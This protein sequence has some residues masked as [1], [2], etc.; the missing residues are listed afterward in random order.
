MKLKALL[1]LM[2]LFVPFTIAGC[3]NINQQTLST[4]KNVKIEQGVLQFNMVE[5]A[6]YYVIYFNNYEITLNPKYSQ[7]SS[8]VDGVVNYDATSIL[9][10][11]K[12]YRIKI[13]AIAEEMKDSAFTN[14]V[15]Y[16]Y[17]K[18]LRKPDNV[19]IV[20]NN[21][22]WDAVET[23]DEYVIKAQNLTKTETKEYK[24]NI[25][26]FDL[27]LALNELGAG[28]Y[29]LFVK[30]VRKGSVAC[31]G[32]YS[33]AVN[34]SNIVKLNTPNIKDIYELNNKIYMQ[35]ELDS[36]CNKLVIDCN[37][38]S[39]DIILTNNNFVTIS[40]KIYTINLT[41]ALSINL[42]DLGQYNFKAKSIYA[43]NSNCYYLDSDFSNNFIHNKTSK[44]AAPTLSLYYSAD[45]G[46]YIASWNSVNNATKYLIVII[47]NATETEKE[48]LGN[49]ILI[50]QPF[51]SIKVKA[52]GVGNFVNSDFSNTLTK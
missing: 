31:V 38:T 13:K 5:N 46:G 49:Q 6:E 12:T 2:C 7:K 40:D 22:V 45:D 32:E 25:N 19:R 28:E 14:E 50:T 9:D 3:E 47:N 18:P 42:T 15:I 34:Y 8:I 52:L 30:A 39:L 11:N 44:L 41:D 24:T 43:T 26:V 10:Y 27:N 36:N 23:A 37:G 20:S 1:L 51:T 4:P 29:N 35:I 16:N 33:N 21:L 48:V 17:V